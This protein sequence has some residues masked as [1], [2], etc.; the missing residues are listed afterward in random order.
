MSLATDGP[1]SI[2]VIYQLLEDALRQQGF[3]LLKGPVGA[4]VI[5]PLEGDS[6]RRFDTSMSTWARTQLQ[7]SPAEGSARIDLRDV[8]LDSLIASMSSM[9]KRRIKFGELPSGTL[10][11]IA[12][13]KFSLGHACLL[14][15]TALELKGLELVELRDGTF[16]V[17]ARR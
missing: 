12:G 1:V 10:S 7:R 5:L 6:G 15:E 14:L 2:P 8:D 9:S 13:R 4:T 3:L 11:V 17:V 16:E